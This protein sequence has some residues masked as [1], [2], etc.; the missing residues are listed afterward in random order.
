VKDLLCAAR[1]TV[2]FRHSARLVKPCAKVYVLELDGGYVYVGKSMDV[3]KRIK[4]HSEGVG[5]GF[6]KRFKPTGRVLDRIGTLQGEGDG[7]ERDE[8]LRQMMRMGSHRVR[9]WKYVRAKHTKAELADIECNIREMMD[10]CRVC[11]REG[12]FAAKCQHRTDRHGFDIR[13]RR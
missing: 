2:S 9:G 13:G 12:H 8:T 6:T 1:R 4:Q 7:P 3:E 10:W 5:S 11:G